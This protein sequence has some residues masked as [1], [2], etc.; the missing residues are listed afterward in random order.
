[1]HASS[2]WRSGARLKL[3]DKWLDT[4]EDWAIRLSGDPNVFK[5]LS[6]EDTVASFARWQR[7]AMGEDWEYVE[8]GVD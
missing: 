3:G 2:A 5:P 7:H 1:M 8:R 6:E 4:F